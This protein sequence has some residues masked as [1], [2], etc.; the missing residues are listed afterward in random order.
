MR[1]V[2]LLDPVLKNGMETG[3]RY[4]QA[5]LQNSDGFFGDFI[6][7]VRSIKEKLRKK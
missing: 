1:S 4:T 7:E 5:F 3:W 6:N 2:L